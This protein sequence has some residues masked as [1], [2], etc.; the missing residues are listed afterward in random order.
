MDKKRFESRIRQLWAI[1]KSVLTLYLDIVKTVEDT[2][3]K[4]QFAQICE[5]EKR[6]AVLSEEI[7]SLLKG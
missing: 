6:H 1:D 7:L 5:D 2:D 3:L 4:K